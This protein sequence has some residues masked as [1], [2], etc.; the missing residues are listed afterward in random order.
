MI[1][2]DGKVHNQD[3]FG[4]TVGSTVLE[5]APDNKRQKTPRRTQA[6]LK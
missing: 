5:D 2:E 6:A 3:S 4:R 1:A